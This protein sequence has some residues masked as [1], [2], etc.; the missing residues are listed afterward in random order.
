M[1]ILAAIPAVL[2]VFLWAAL[3]AILLNLHSSDPAGNGLAQVYAVVTVFALWALLLV[4][5]VIAVAAGPGP[6]WMKAG[7]VLLCLLSCAA[8]LAA[9]E[10]MSQR[11]SH[12]VNWPIVVAAIVPPLLIA[13]GAWA[14]IPSLHGSVPAGTVALAIGLPVLALSLAPLPPIIE[15][16]SRIA[17]TRATNEVKF[18]AQLAEQR[19]AKRQE[20]LARLASLTQ[21][22]P[23][24]DWLS[25][26]DKDSE[27]RERALAAIRTLRRRQADAELMLGRGMSAPLL[28]AQDLDLQATAA[29][30]A[31]A[32]AYLHARAENFRP[33]ADPP[34]YAFAAPRIEMFLPTMEWLVRNGCDCSAELAEIA[35]AVRGYPDSP[36]RQQFLDRLARLR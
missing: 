3:I 22:T 32:R 31:S 27:V 25:L 11:G 28:E 7:A 29:F 4:I 16:S 10:L 36:E 2:A 33:K 30:C 19:Q 14:W 26:V 1:T 20:Q 8:A 18:A 12:R 9:L 21:D 34:P 15:R 17:A 13:Y 5:V 35:D 6:G 23:L 24:W